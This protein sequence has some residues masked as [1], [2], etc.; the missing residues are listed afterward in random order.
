MYTI[1]ICDDEADFLDWLEKAL[2]RY[3]EEA[4]EPFKII[5]FGEGRQL[6]EARTEKLNLIFLDVRMPG[7]NGIRT[8][9]EI[10]KKDEG[11]DIIF[12][13]S[14]IQ[15]AVSGYSVKALSYLVKPLPYDVLK[16][17][18]DRWLGSIKKRDEVFWAVQN[19][20]GTYRIML[21]SLQYIETYNR[22]LLIHTDQ[23][24]I[25][26]YK[27]LRDVEAELSPHGFSRSHSGFLVNLFYVEAVEKLEAKLTS[28]GS[29]PISKQRKKK[30]M[31]DLAAYWGDRL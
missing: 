20:A 8:A 22:N 11:V 1:A 19:D 14:M 31:E 26:C 29:V 30:F 25:V 21:K 15:H 3:A 18:L 27:K 16:A 6:L 24:R 7:L 10:R 13:T 12:L 4:G 9:E 23:D 5:R 17:E 28:G 2:M